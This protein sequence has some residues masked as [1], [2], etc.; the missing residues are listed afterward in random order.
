MGQGGVYTFFDD[1]PQ[2]IHVGGRT[3][4]NFRQLGLVDSGPSVTHK[5]GY[6]FA[7]PLVAENYYKHVPQFAQREHAVRDM[8]H[9]RYPLARREVYTPVGFI[10]IL[11]PDTVVEIKNFARWKH[12]LGQVLAYGLHYPDRT[13]IIHAYILGERKPNLKPILGVCDR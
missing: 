5:H 10:D 13:K 7:S 12:A 3:I 4:E 1:K 9:V 11:L 8:L 2:H 6:Y